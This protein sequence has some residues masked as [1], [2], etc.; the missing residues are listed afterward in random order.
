MALLLI[1][2]LNYIVSEIT[3]SSKF[4]VMLPRGGGA[5]IRWDKPTLGWQ[6]YGFHKKKKIIFKSGTFIDYHFKLHSFRNNSFLKIPGNAAQGG[7][8]VL[9]SGGIRLC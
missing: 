9:S 6:G 5:L 3:V 7:G 8:G 4:P 1:I 2:I